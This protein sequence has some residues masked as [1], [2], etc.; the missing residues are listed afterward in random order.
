MMVQPIAGSQAWVVVMS[1][2]L[3]TAT[4][5]TVDPSALVPSSNFQVARLGT[6]RQVQAGM[7]RID[8]IAGTLIAES[9]RQL[10][11]MDLNE[12]HRARAFVDDGYLSGEPGN[13]ELYARVRELNAVDSEQTRESRV[14]TFLQAGME[15]L[16]PAKGPALNLLNVA[17]RTGVIV[18]LA[19][20]L[21]QA[22]TYHVERA[23]AE[24]DTPEAARAWAVVAITLI[25]PA[26]TLVGAA[27][28]K[29][30]GT[31]SL[32]SNVG[33]ACMASITLGALIAAHLTDTT[34]NLLPAVVG[35]AIYTV[36]RGLAN[37]CFPLLDNSG[38]GNVSTAVVTT[39][40]YGAAQYVLKHVGDLAPLSGAARAAAELGHSLGADAIQGLLNGFGMVVDDVIS[41]VCK[42][43]QMLAPSRGLDSVFSDPESLEQVVLKVRA[44]VQRPTGSQ[45]ADAAFNIGAMRLSAG[46]AIALVLHAVA[47]LLNDSE[48]EE[49]YQA[50]ILNGCL[51]LMAMAIYL[52][53]V[54]GSGKRTDNSFEPRETPLP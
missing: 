15:W 54:F 9:F 46:H 50:H 19:E 53:L 40:A 52:P 31:G 1:D 11:E 45:L 5:A 12:A 16:E 28:N 23:L 17:G 35:G 13:E 21:R 42:S 41:I 39:G 44:G 30:N 34:R 37:A 32:A 2:D 4:R 49:G 38:G 47:S 51:A 43:C 33:R 22:A 10:G 18:M 48:V 27:R 24:G 3:S 26:L 8:N 36:A 20:M 29:C 6:A 25:G 14:K 7:R